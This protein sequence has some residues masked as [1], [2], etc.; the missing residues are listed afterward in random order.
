MQEPALIIVVGANSLLCFIVLLCSKRGGPQ[1]PSAED[2]NDLTNDD[3][4]YCY[5]TPQYFG[6]LFPANVAA[7]ESIAA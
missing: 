2:K 7:R 5:A 3:Y 4:L 6:L 1:T